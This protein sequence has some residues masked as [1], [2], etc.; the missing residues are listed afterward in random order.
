VVSAV[1]GVGIGLKITSIAIEEPRRSVSFSRWSVVIDDMRM[2][3]VAEVYP[4][5]AFMG[6][7][8][9]IEHRDRSVVGLYD[10]RP[11]QIAAHPV[12]QRAH[13]LG[14]IGNPATERRAR[15][16]LRKACRGLGSWRKSWSASTETIVC[17]E[18]AKV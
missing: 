17:P 3:A 4:K 15:Q 13:Q 16:P 12:D 5:P 14:G 10:A 8:L 6:S 2:A 18:H 1:A 7:T 11:Q 9:I